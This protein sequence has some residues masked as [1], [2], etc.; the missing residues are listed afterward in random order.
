MTYATDQDTTQ[1][2]EQFRQYDVDT[3]LA[4]LW[5]G[6]LDIK[7]DL[8]PDPAHSADVAAHA[9]C[10]RIRELPK[11]QQLQAQQDILSGASS[12]WGREYTSLSSSGR[13]EVWLLLGQGMEDGSI[14]QVPSDYQLPSET[15]KFTEAIAKLS[16]EQRINFMRSAVMEMGAPAG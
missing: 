11:E 5:F 7:D 9:Y 15:N 3:Q 13:L 2:L 1:A 4:L 16:F 10:D 6:Y 12:E 14:I 8:S